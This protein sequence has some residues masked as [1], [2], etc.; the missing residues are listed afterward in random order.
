MQ[1]SS[2]EQR[3]GRARLGFTLIELLVVI[4]IISILAAIIFPVFAAAREKARETTCLS[5]LRQIGLAV[6]MYQDD[7]NG[8]MPNRKDLKSSLPGGYMPWAPAWPTSDPRCG[9]AA[10][11]FSPYTKS[12]AIWACPDVAGNKIGMALEV[13]QATST[14]PNATTTYYWMWR[15]DRFDDSTPPEDFWGLTDAEAVAELD[16]ANDPKLVPEYPQSTAD[17]EMA[18]DPYFPRTVKTVP[19]D[20]KGLAVHFGGRNRLFLDGHV[21]WLRDVREND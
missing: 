11:V 19:N 7:A 8:I 6:E 18:E 1:Y 5:N 2:V 20:I 13:P 12:G 3:S 14:A 16:A 17:V 10:V 21:Q 15:F 4:A 9:W